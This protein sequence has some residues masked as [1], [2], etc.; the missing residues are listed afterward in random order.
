LEAK[1][2]TKRSLWLLAMTAGALGAGC[3]EALESSEPLGETQE[4]LWGPA[5][6]LESG[7]GYANMVSVAMNEA[8][9]G[10]ATWAQQGASGAYDVWARRFKTTVGWSQ[11]FVVDTSADNAGTPFA[12]VD[13]AGN[14]MVA[15][16]RWDGS[17]WDTVA[18]YFVQGSGWQAP[19]VVAQD[20]FLAG[21]AAGADSSIF[22]LFSRWDGV[23]QDLSARRFR[24][25]WGPPEVIS[26]G[27]AYGASIA[28]GDG[29][30]VVVWEEWV[31]GRYDIWSNRYTPSG[32]WVG[33]VLLENNNAGSAQN[34]S[35]DVSITGHALAVW[36]Q[37]DGQRFNVWSKRFVPGSGWSSNVL[38]EN[39]NAGDAVNARVA[40]DDAGNAIAVWQQFNGTQTNVLARRYVANT[41]W[42]PVGTLSTNTGTNATLPNIAMNAAGHALA[43]WSDTSASD[44]SQFGRRFRPNIGWD[45][46]ELVRTYANGEA[47]TAQVA[48]SASGHGAGAWAVYDGH[49]WSNAWASEFT[50]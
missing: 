47:S 42:S 32:G 40:T 30:A 21:L 35:V 8:G 19:V 20:G 46:A 50:P 37:S 24:G 27:D 26:G 41:G 31:G 6:L 16:I 48:I 36:E 11:P 45:P 49:L 4:A 33:P 5:A 3:A 25:D 38:V 34:A 12:V 39:A 7:S 9:D 29:D 22:L 14:I 1:M 13:P 17:D 18:R 2:K 23:E 44:F 28:M 15:W 43:M 10:I